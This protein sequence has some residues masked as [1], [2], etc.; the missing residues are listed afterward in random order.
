[1]TQ[2]WYPSLCDSIVILTLSF[3]FRERYIT[4]IMLYDISIC[5]SKHNGSFLDNSVLQFSSH[6]SRCHSHYTN[7]AKQ[8]SSFK[9]YLID[10]WYI[11][12]TVLFSPSSPIH[13]VWTF[14]ST[15][16]RKERKYPVYQVIIL[17]HKTRA[18]W[19]AY[20][21]LTCLVCV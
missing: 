2:W 12:I 21:S 14:K 6:N 19:L 9:G 13:K 1:M 8:L 3:V 15:C 16:H 5:N 20:L 17:W 11:I 4:E 7:V 18:T 10:H